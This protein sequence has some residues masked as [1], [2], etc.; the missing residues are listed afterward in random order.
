MEE[1]KIKDNNYCDF[2][3]KTD[4]ALLEEFNEDLK[5]FTELTQNE[6]LSEIDFTAIDK[7]GRKTHIELKQRKGTIKD[8]I[9]FKTIIIEPSKIARTTKIMESGYTL[10]EQRLFMNFVDDGVIIFN[11]NRISKLEYYPNHKHF[12]PIKGWENE[13]RFGLYITEAIIYEKNENGEYKREMVKC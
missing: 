4:A 12:N 3:E 10:D 8:F 9:K 6:R 7:K 2:Q 1:K 11:L 13:D 5:W